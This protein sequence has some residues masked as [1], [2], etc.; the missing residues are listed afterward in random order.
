M[1]TQTI[2]IDEYNNDGSLINLYYNESIGEWCAYGFSAYRLW[3]FCKSNGYNT[4]QSFSQ[5]MQM[6]CLI[7][8][9]NAFMQLLQNMTDI[10][11][12]IDSHIRIIM[13]EKITMNAYREWVKTLRSKIPEVYKL[14]A[15][16]T[17]YRHPFLYYFYFGKQ[18]FPK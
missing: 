8:A 3:L 4:L 14:Q 10:T 6:P 13:P 17:R 12:Q 18:S 5:E 16:P 11:E 15:R 7:I 9:K 2:T 1:N